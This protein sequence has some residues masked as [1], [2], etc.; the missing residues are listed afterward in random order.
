MTMKLQV[1][2]IWTALTVAIVWG[3]VMYDASSPLVP[4]IAVSAL[5]S[6]TGTTIIIAALYALDSLVRRVLISAAPKL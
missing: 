1:V 3:E 4:T 5:F 2:S 6:A